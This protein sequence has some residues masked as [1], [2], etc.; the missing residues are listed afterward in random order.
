[1]AH[2]EMT[3]SDLL[4]EADLTWIDSVTEIMAFNLQIM[5]PLDTVIAHIVMD[6]DVFQI[7]SNVEASINAECELESPIYDAVEHDSFPN[8]R[9]NDGNASPCSP[10]YLQASPDDG[11]SARRGWRVWDRTHGGA[12]ARND[13]VGGSRGG[14]HMS[15]RRATGRRR[16]RSWR[17]LDV[18]GQTQVRVVG[19]H[20]YTGRS[21]AQDTSL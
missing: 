12:C 7:A 8:N 1:M 13:G 3:L 2:N 10:D 14:V 4:D 11:T 19:R 5:L 15:S 20:H 16:R 18:D 21:V 17:N 6:D 9:A